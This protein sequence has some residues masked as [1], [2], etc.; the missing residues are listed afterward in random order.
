VEGQSSSPIEHCSLD[1]IEYQTKVRPDLQKTPFETSDKFFV[2]GSSQVI[3]GK[4]H[5]GYLVVTKTHLTVIES[6]RLPNNWSVQNCELFALNQ[7]LKL[8]EKR[9]GT[10]YTDPKY[11]FGVV[12]TFRKI[13]TK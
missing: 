11:A 2:D 9:E 8:L 1:L 13:W 12:Q 4:R 5:N 7:A 10:V 6:G 3:E